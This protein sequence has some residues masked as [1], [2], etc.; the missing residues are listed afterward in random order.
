[1]VGARRADELLTGRALSA[2]ALL[3]TGTRAVRS[4]ATVADEIDEDGAAPLTAGYR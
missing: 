1:M 2:C 3:L 4:P